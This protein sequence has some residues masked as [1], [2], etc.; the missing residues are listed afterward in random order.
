L[1]E[2]KPQ[3]RSLYSPHLF[4]EKEYHQHHSVGA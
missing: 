4:G 3:V 2:C 1:K